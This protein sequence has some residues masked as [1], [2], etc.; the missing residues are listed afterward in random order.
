MSEITA[1]ELLKQK[2]L[3]QAQ[4]CEMTKVHKSTM[5]M[6]VKHNCAS[7]ETIDRIFR[8]TGVRVAA[9]MSRKKGRPY[10]DT[11]IPPRPAPQPNAP[12]PLAKWLDRHGMTQ[13]EFAKASG[14]EKSTVSV[15]VN[16]KVDRVSAEYAARLSA[17][18]DGEV[19]IGRAQR[20]IIPRAGKPRA[21]NGHS[22]LNDLDVSDVLE[23]IERFDAMT[24]R[25]RVAMLRFLSKRYAAG[26]L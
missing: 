13:A 26:G 4:L 5:S 6:L 24:K 8:A 17:A 21:R 18:T 15:I 22:G 2:G 1:A 7:P 25:A 20:R 19:T 23:M 14:I 16:G 3:T 9:K 12:T 10:R 11:P